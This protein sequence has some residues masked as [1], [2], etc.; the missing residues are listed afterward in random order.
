M[1]SCEVQTDATVAVSFDGVWLGG[2]WSSYLS[3]RIENNSD[4]YANN[5]LWD[6]IWDTENFEMHTKLT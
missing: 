5:I 1:A 2:Y 6:Q 4:L 3:E